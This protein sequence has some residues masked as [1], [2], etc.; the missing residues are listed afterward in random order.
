[1]VG[2]S[3]VAYQPNRNCA[4]NRRLT[5]IRMAGWFTLCIRPLGLSDA[6]A[7]SSYHMRAHNRTR[8]ISN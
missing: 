8:E 4:T 3:R 2:F 6:V 7:P 1:M 5:R